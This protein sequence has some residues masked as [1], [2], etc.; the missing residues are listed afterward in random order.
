MLRS[1]TF[2]TIHVFFE[3]SKENWVNELEGKYKTFLL[4]SFFYVAGWG[5]RELLV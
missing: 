1:M 2:K 4:F 3:V 5:G